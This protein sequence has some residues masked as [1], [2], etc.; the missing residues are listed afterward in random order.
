MLQQISYSN[1]YKK[2]TETDWRRLQELHDVPSLPVPA[3]YVV[4]LER[5]GYT[6]NIDTGEVLLDANGH[7]LECGHVSGFAELLREMIQW[8]AGGAEGGRDER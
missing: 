2:L 5:H 6:L 1:Y 7:I 4:E 8:Q 3:V